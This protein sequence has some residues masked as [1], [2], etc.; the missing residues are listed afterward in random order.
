MNIRTILVEEYVKFVDSTKK[1]NKYFKI[2]I[3]DCYNYVFVFCFD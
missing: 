2:Y 1:Q 3:F